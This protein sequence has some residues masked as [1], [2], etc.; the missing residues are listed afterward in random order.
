MANQMDALYVTSRV[1]EYALGSEIIEASLFRLELKANQRKRLSWNH[2]YIGECSK[3]L[4]R[5]LKNLEENRCVT[6]IDY[7]D[8]LIS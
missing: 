8:S 2:T 6:C 3:S 1:I 4:S 5:I 7:L